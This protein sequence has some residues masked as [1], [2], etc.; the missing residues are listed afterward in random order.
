MEIKSTAQIVFGIKV[1]DSKLHILEEKS[2]ELPNIYTYNTLD[3]GGEK[4][5]GF[6]VDFQETYY[7]F[8]D[9]KQINFISKEKEQEVCK[10][11]IEHFQQQP[12]YHLI[13]TC[14]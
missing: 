6:L 10:L 1:A 11:L 8:S 13:V 3:E 5:I 12:S 7:N 14:S 4:I 2:Q 9:T